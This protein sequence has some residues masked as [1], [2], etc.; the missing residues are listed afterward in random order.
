MRKKRIKI[1]ISIDDVINIFE[2]LNQN[3]YKSIFEN[4]TLALLRKF[5]NTYNMKFN[6]Y[7][8]CENMDSS[9]GLENCTDKYQKEFRKNKSWLKINF[10]GL[11]GTVDLSTLDMVK[12]KKVFNDFQKQIKRICGFKLTDLTR[13]HSYSCTSN[14]L[15]FLK[16]KKIKSLFISETNN[17]CYNLSNSEIKTIKQN[18]NYIINNINYINAHIRLD[19]CQNV[20]E[21]LEKFNGYIYIYM[22]EWMFFDDFEKM[23]NNIILIGEYAKENKCRFI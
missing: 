8:F 21:K 4:R 23:K 17:R 6:L 7:C 18:D 3:H 5:N 19:N 16:K 2:D 10:H 22:H 14:Q 9:F 20:S 13:L 12:Y 11:N 15:R 1:H